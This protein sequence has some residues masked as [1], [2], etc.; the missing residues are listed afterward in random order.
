MNAAERIG[1][2]LEPS[3]RKYLRGFYAISMRFF[4]Q[5]CLKMPME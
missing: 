5:I 1:R 3:G 2:A 4:S